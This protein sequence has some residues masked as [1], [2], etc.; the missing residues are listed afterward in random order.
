MSFDGRLW[1]YYF[2]WDFAYFIYILLHIFMSCTTTEQRQQYET[3]VNKIWDALFIHRLRTNDAN[4]LYYLPY[5]R[6]APILHG[7]F[8]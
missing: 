4:R 5:K 2:R 6:A 8:S 7:E 3:F 1:L